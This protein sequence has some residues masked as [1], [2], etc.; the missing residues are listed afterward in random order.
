MEMVAGIAYAD[1]KINFDGLS[2]YTQ[3]AVLT[4]NNT[5]KNCYPLIASSLGNHNVIEVHAGEEHKNLDTCKLIWQ[6]LTDLNFD[7]H[8]LLII[9]GGGV[10]GDMGGFCAATLKRGIDFILVP[11]TLLSQ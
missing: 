1:G 7:R 2:Q 4:D 11:T 10:L 5:H 8:S 6:K 3:I 9:L